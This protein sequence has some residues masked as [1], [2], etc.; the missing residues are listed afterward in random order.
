MEGKRI[1]E[2]LTGKVTE[3]LRRRFATGAAA[4]RQRLP[5]GSPHAPVTDLSLLG[6]GAR[7]DLRAG[8]WD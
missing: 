8:R 6:G 7:R 3:R 5:S 4:A 1:V 2:I